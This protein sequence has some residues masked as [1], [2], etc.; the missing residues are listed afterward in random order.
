MPSRSITSLF[1]LTLFLAGCSGATTTHTAAWIRANADRAYWQTRYDDAAEGYAD[2]ARRN[3]GDWEAHHRL[4]RCHVERGDLK[5]ARRSIELAY[6]LHPWNDA[7]TQ[8]MVDILNQQGDDAALFTFLQS[9]AA[10]QPSTSAW[11]SLAWYALDRDDPDTAQAA[12]DEAITIDRGATVAPYLA[13]A[14]LAWHLGDREAAIRN[15]R[16][17]S[18][19]DA[20]DSQVQSRLRD[21]GEV[22]GPS[23]AMPPEGADRS[24]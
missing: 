16:Y 24:E 11:L 4:A 7:I 17:A 15:L 19:I 2:L 20:A 6:A 1:L 22:P 3:P 9:H 21:L 13:A 8:R 10:T 5:A 14:D 23:I 12:I 18:A